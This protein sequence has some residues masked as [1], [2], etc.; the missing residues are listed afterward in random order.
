MKKLK[1]KKIFISGG[2][3]VIGNYLVKKLHNAGSIIF[4]GDLKPRPFCWP[5]DIIYRQGDLNFITRQEIEQFA[6]E[7]FFHLAATFERSVENYEFWDKNRWHNLHL[8]SFLMGLLK[9]SRSLRHVIFAS[10]YLIYDPKLYK[11]QNPPKMPYYL[12]ESDPIFPRNLTGA[13]KLNHEMELQ[14]LNKFRNKQFT[15]ISARIFRSYGIDSRDVISRWIRDLLADKELIVYRKEGIFDYVYAEDVAEGLIRLALLSKSGIFNLGS[16]SGRKIEKVLEVLKSHFPAMKYREQDEDIAWEA[17]QADV[18]KLHKM[19]GWKPV[20][21]IEDSIPII[22]EHEKKKLLAEVLHPDFNVMITSAAR[23]IPMIQGI[24][25]AMNKLNPSMRLVAADSDPYCIGRYFTDDFWEMPSIDQLKRQHVIEYCKANKIRLIIPSRDGELVF[26]S[27]FRAE[28]ENA[29]I[30]VMICSPEVTSLAIDKLEFYRVLKAEGF[31]V[32]QTSTVL[33][34][35]QRENYIVVKDRFG[36]GSID[37]LINATK[38]IA[39]ERAAQ[40]DNPVFQPFIEG[41]EYSVDAYVDK[42][43]AVKGLMCR[44]REL[45]VAGESQ[46]TR[47]VNDPLLENL[48]KGILKKW[49]FYGHVIVQ[50]LKDGKGRYHIIEMNCRFGG[51]STLS[52]ASGLDSFYWLL[53]ETC[54]QDLRDYPFIPVYNKLQIRYPKD[55]IKDGTSF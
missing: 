7:Y 2:N 30:N 54:G 33:G 14:F 34:D 9:D 42:N 53:L 46:V 37:I 55:L 50:V 22:I 45:V 49:H 5:K 48:I 16:G 23:K 51:A 39:L 44:V 24:R 52:V 41:L 10:S 3:G 1:N 47:T 35:I 36:A 32:I 17:S 31:P 21:Q 27:K 43:G 6:P 19:T 15:T 4:V 40:M 25:Y 20:F 8:S 12:K 18:T 28:L 38:D 11:F 29:G 26:W 13:A